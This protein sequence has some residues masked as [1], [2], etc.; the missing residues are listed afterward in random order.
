MRLRTI[1]EI[2]KKRHHNVAV[3]R[4]GDAIAAPPVTAARSMLLYSI[5]RLLTKSLWPRR[6]KHVMLCFAM[7]NDTA[8]GITSVG[9]RS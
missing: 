4:S 7:L 8:S 1:Y 5:E 2:I 3:S 9:F 6:L